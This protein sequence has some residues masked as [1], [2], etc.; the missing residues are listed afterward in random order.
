MHSFKPIKQPRVSDAVFDQLK[1]SI[2]LRHFKPGDRLPSER[3]L[4]EEFQDEIIKKHSDVVKMTVEL[5]QRH[6]RRVVTNAEEARKILGMKLTSK[7]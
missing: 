7:L 1:Q 5:A 2:F 3:K 6:G 4:S